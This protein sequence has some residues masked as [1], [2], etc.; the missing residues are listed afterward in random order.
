[1]KPSNDFN[2]QFATA[3]ERSLEGD[4]ISLVP[5]PARQRQKRLDQLECL[6]CARDMLALLTRENGVPAEDAW[7][8]GLPRRAGK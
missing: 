3:N 5:S 2:R 1:M 6:S 4:G 8:Q 7:R